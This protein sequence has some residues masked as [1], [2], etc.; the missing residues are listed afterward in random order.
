MVYPALGCTA[1][2]RGFLA[3]VPLMTV[4][5]NRLA[6]STSVRTISMRPRTPSTKYKCFDTQSKAI[7]STEWSRLST[8]GTE[9]L[10]VDR[11]TFCNAQYSLLN[12]N[13]KDYI[14][15]STNFK[16][17]PSLKIYIFTKFLDCSEKK[18]CLKNFQDTHSDTTLIAL[19]YHS[20]T[21]ERNWHFSL[22]FQANKQKKS[23]TIQRFFELP[24]PKSILIIQ[25]LDSQEG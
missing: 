3:T 6:S 20:D 8:T 21:F 11:H 2:P 4:F 24:L 23:S 12:L 9:P 18:N 5:R 1:M 15:C 17:A 14:T 19:W 10:P 7:P 25:P 22:N 13:E 16:G